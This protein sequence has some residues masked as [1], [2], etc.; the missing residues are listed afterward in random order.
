MNTISDEDKPRGRK[1][2]RM[3]PYRRVRL[4]RWGKSLLDRI[5]AKEL[6]QSEFASRAGV[7]TRKKFMGRDLVSNYIR[8]ETQPTPLYQIAMA[9]ALGITVD[10]LMAP[11]ND[12]MPVEEKMAHKKAPVEMQEVAP[13]RMRLKIDTELPWVVGVEILRLI[14]SAEK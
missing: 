9:K 3:D 8:G 6:N 12:T 2:P 5:N 14:H 1:I 10:E 13:N 4:K 11:M 7:F